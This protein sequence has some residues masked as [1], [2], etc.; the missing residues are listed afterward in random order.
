MTEPTPPSSEQ[1]KAIERELAV[2]GETVDEAA[3]LVEQGGQA[4]LA[5]LGARV[6]TVCASLL[7]LPPLEARA[8]GARLPAIAETLDGIARALNERGA[9]GVGASDSRVS[10]NQAARAYGAAMSKGRR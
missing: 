4:D 7:S 6:E 8:I 9:T 5:I 1:G 2:I 3:R 10:P